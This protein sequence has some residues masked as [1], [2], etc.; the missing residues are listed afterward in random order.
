MPPAGVGLWIA[1]V[2]RL[3]NNMNDFDCHGCLPDQQPCMIFLAK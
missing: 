1:V 2:G 3:T